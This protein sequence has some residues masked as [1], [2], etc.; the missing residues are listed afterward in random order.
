MREAPKL[1]QM[2]AED[3]EEQENDYE[4]KK[5]QDLN[6]KNHVSWP[7]TPQMRKRLDELMRNG[8]PTTTEQRKPI[9]GR[10]RLQ[11]WRTPKAQQNAHSK[12]GTSTDWHSRLHK[13]EQSTTKTQ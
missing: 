12:T 8:R 3:E 10:G 5:I 11:R 9:S 2:T 4:T 6:W 1:H 7:Q 13:G